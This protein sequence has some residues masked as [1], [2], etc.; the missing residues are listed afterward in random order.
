MYARLHLGVVS[1][2]EH[3][4]H[5]VLMAVQARS[6]RHARIARFDLNRIV[7][8][9]QS[10]GQRMEKTIVG[11][12]NPLT[13]KIVGQVTIVAHRHRVMAARLPRVQVGL[14][15]VT[16]G[17]GFRFVAQVTGTLTIAESEGGGPRQQSQQ[18]RKQHHTDTVEF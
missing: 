6:L 17:A 13:N 8:V 12:S 11:F 4:M 18:D 1:Y 15:D 9:L 5:Y 10:E 14:H 3:G 16:V 7:V 2:G